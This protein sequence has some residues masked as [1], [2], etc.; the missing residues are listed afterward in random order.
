MKRY[1]VSFIVEIDDQKDY[2]TN[3]NDWIFDVI[4]NE[5]V[6]EDNECIVDFSCKE[7]SEN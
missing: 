2:N 5:L 7:V 4:Q 3:P 6:V 1:M